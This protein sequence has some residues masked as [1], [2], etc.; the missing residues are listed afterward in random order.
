MFKH[1]GI[2]RTFS[3]NLYLASLLSAVAGMVNIAGFLSFHTLTTNVTG[4][5]TQ[6]SEELYNGDFALASDLLAYVLSFLL[7]ALL[8]GLLMEKFTEGMRPLSYI[9]PIFIEILLLT[10]VALSPLAESRGYAISFTVLSCFLLFAMGLQN[11]L[12]TKISRSVVRTTHLTGLFTDLGLDLAQLLRKR[13]RRR[14]LVKYRDI[15]LKVAIIFCF[16]AGGFVSAFIYPHWQLKTLLLPAALLLFTLWYDRILLR[17]AQLLRR[18]Q[19][20]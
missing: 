15:Y 11:A 19:G 7:G 14:R 1:V 18:L 13:D 2:R 10:M 5:V 6:L 12:V 4:H 8:S 9:W 16:F 3:H 17:Y 20:R